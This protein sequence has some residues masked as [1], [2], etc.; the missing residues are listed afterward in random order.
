MNIPYTIERRADTGVNNVELGVWLFLASEV[1]LFGGLFSAYFTLRTGS[2]TAWTP[3]REHIAPAVLNTVLL[4]GGSAAL[5]GARRA[6]CGGRI[7]TFR[8]WMTAAILLPLFFVP[9]KLL[10][11][12]HWWGRGVTAAT[13]T[14]WGMYFLLTGVHAAHVAGGVIVNA[15]LA[16]TTRDVPR[17]VNRLASAVLY[18]FFVDLVW[19]ALVAVL[20]VW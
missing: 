16:A 3:L 1:M 4:V 9:H 15:W 6:A 10:E 5:A 18:W 8:G 20:Y 14:Q 13:S 17:L 19:L 11:Y 12:Q 7:G 2:V